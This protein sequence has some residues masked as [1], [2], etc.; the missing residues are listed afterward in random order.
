MTD[1]TIN[2][3]KCIAISGKSILSSSAKI[4]LPEISRCTYLEYRTFCDL[5]EC[6]ILHDEVYV[7]GDFSERENQA[8]NLMKSLNTLN[9]TDFIHVINDSVDKLF[10]NRTSIDVQL[11]KIV[12]NT[13]NSDI[14]FIR[15][16]LI[17]KSFTYRYN[18]DE[19]AAFL[20]SIKSI[21]LENIEL[22]KNKIIN[23]FD[24]SPNSEFVK[25]LFRG[26]LIASVAS[27]LNGTAKF[28]GLRKPIGFLIKKKNKEQHFET[29]LFKLYQHVNGLYLKKQKDNQNEF[30][31]PLLFSIFLKHIKKNKNPISVIVNLRNEFQHM[32]EVYL[33]I[34]ITT[35]KEANKKS[36]SFE[37]TYKY[38]DEI[39]RFASNNHLKNL[40]KKYSNEL[41]LDSSSIEMKY[42]VN[43]S[44][45]ESDGD[46]NASST[47]NIAKIVKN[48][49][50]FLVEFTRNGV[51]N[52]K[53][54]PLTTYLVKQLNTDI[55]PIEDFIKINEFNKKRMKS[56]DNLVTKNK[57]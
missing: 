52:R 26:F 33:N 18:E 6:V 5:L 15:K 13:F 46:S 37:N 47:I 43:D 54:K 48:A 28:T 17:P 57:M 34:P 44:E 32:R 53:N 50:K 55:L 7:L 9:K 1:T 14:S 27:I 39:Y 24:N 20:A 22:L 23:L 10:I 42:E 56:Y 30:Y 49:I 12:D 38:F 40:G 36:K 16:Q 8:S 29:N 11:K 25:H 3:N 19:K 2:T 35:K 21:D 4:L 41:L 31:Q 45:N 51:I